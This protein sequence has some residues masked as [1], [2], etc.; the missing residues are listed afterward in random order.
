M[1]FS[2]VLFLT[3]FLPIT[4]GVYFLSQEKLRHYVLLFASLLFY[5]WGEPIA[6]FIM[7]GLIFISYIASFK[8]SSSHSSQ[9]CALKRKLL[10]ASV[11]FFNF[12]VLF[13]YK[14]LGFFT[15]NINF[16]LGCLNIKSFDVPKIKLPIGISFYIFQIVS[17]VVD[18]YRGTVKPQKNIF[19]LAMYVSLFPQLIAGPIVRYETIEKDL[20]NRSTNFDNIYEGLKRFVVGLAKKV[21]IADQMA[22]AADIIFNWPVQEVPCFFAWIGALCY[23]LQIFYDFSGYSDMAIGLGR[24]FNF[25]FLENFN[26][27]YSS[28][29]VQEFWRRWHISL[30]SWL[31]DYLYIP[32][33]GNRKG[34]LRTYINSYI[35]FILCGLW[36]G[37]TYNFLVW[38]LYHGFGL[39]VE[40][41]GFGKFL[42]KLPKFI[43]NLY[44][45]LFVVIGWVIFRTN[46]LADA[47]VYLKV[48]F[49]GNKNVRISDFYDAT[50]FLTYSNVWIMIIGILFS[51]PV[52]KSCL[53]KRNSKLFIIQ[54][55]SLMLLF[56]C[57]Y[58]F[59]V[60]SSFSPFIYF[61]F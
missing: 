55:I 5:S 51:Y 32:L 11:L 29:S 60:T 27:P 28:L 20:K 13:F 15:E 1:V 50:L 26:Y 6:V 42:N 17:Y 58:V 59:A 49:T 38:G 31:R 35:V 24:I 25:H 36:H 41:A 4:L 19:K 40:K 48:M 21:L 30:S 52:F 39:S 34:K 7:L 33:G 45:W 16:L 56:G 57:A 43:A 12:S 18:V 10:L 37:A 22:Y 14:Y 46:N 23:T 2:S 47:L 9:R 3:M 61:R 54:N 8:L 53:V 44:L